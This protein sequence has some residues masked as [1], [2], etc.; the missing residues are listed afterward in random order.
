MRTTI[1]LPDQ[2]HREAK[3]RAARSGLSL[4]DLIT[5]LV[6]RGLRQ[7]DEQPPVVRQRRPDLPAVIAARG[8]RMPL[9]SNTETQAILDATVAKAEHG[10][11][12]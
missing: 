12:D 11:R 5:R 4:K 6:E 3:S 10:S 2:L 8:R 9:L 7:G 1:D